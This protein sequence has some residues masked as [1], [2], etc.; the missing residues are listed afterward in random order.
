MEFDVLL[1]LLTLVFAL[2]ASIHY[3]LS[4]IERL[5]K[6]QLPQDLSVA[7]SVSSNT[8]GANQKIGLR[9]TQAKLQETIPWLMYICLYIPYACGLQGLNCLELH[10]DIPY[11]LGF[12][13][14]Q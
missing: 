9:L 6:Q 3:T 4:I 1:R 5:R 7:D 11:G 10:G 12:H 13:L 2:P 8:K 14:G